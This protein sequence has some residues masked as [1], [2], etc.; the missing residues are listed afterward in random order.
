MSLGPD[1]FLL[2]A[3][4]EVDAMLPDS[5]PIAPQQQL[6][7]YSHAEIANQQQDQYALAALLAHAAN[8]QLVEA[9]GQLNQQ[10]LVYA[11]GVT[12]LS[13]RLRAIR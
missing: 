1:S 6:L 12:S 7:A 5:P 10:T 3:M 8:G 9:H 11:D 2:E 4:R 13:A